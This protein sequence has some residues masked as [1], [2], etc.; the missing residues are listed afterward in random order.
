VTTS[1][2]N[3]DEPPRRASLWSGRFS[4][5][6]H[7]LFKVFNDSLNFDRRLFPQELAGS[8]AWARALERANVLEA[9]EVSRIEE[10]L[11][12]LARCVADSP[13]VLIDAD[14][15]DIHSF[16]ER[17]LVARVGD[18]GKKLHT[19]RSRNDQVATDLRLWTMEA[20]DHRIGEIQAVITALVELAHREQATVFPGYTHLQRAQPVLFAHWCLAYVEMLRRDLGRMA[21]A[22]SRAS[23]CPLGCAA[24]AGTAYDID[25]EAIAVDLGFRAAAANS[26]DAVSDRDFVI[27]SLS[28]ISVTAVHLSR[29]AEDLVFYSSGEA[30]L[31]ELPDGLCSGSS[32]MPQKKNPDALELI[33]GKCGMQIGRL[34]GLMTTMKALP[35]A[36]NKDMQE[37]KVPLFDAMDEL[38]ICLRVLPPLLDG[39]KVRRENARVAALGDF[40][41]AT[42]LADH[43][44]AR[45][46]P[47]RDAHHQVGRLVA[48]AIERGLPLEELSLTEIQAH[49]P[50]ADE[51][52][53]VDLTVDAALGKRASIGGT[54]PEQIALRIARLRTPTTKS[55][56]VGSIAVRTARVSDL[57][58]IKRLVDLW[59][60]AGENLPRSE[61]EILQ[62]IGDFTV[63][64]EDDQVVGCG[65]L[66]LYTPT[67]AEIRSVGVD[68]KCQGSGVGSRIV[69]HLAETACKLRIEQVFVLT[70]APRFFE[71]LQFKTVSVNGLPEKILKDCARC[72]K[73]HCCDEI[74]MIRT[75]WAT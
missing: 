4:G 74:A 13:A 16:V 22:Q 10:A 31:I 63:A 7:D 19:G 40:S 50:A 34:V 32:I 72:P 11:E 60:D 14:D 73:K 52:V 65:A 44:V 2:L 51:Q 54:S 59:A 35:L 15:E 37:D 3:I 46:V 61:E 24:L 68:P 43:L 62:S 48:A 42:E 9:E 47:F 23:F 56:P 41:N 69:E 6:V 8:A 36:Y 39:I 17:E 55:R 49:A 12:D 25:R 20:L 21:D 26:L 5:D 66:W 71:R 38:S 29:M 30:R 28:G 53:F 58:D 75:T 45:G 1:D 57:A 64:T 18:L 33:R 27:E 70:R 67:L